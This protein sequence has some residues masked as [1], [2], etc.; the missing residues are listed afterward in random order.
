M[1][2]MTWRRPVP[3]TVC[4]IATFLTLPPSASA[5]FNGPAEC[6]GQSATLVGEAG[7]PLEGTDGP[8][9]VV[10][11]GVGFVE[12]YGGDDLVCITGSYDAEAYGDHCP[13]FAT[14]AGRD[15]IDSSMMAE[16]P[17]LLL[18]ID[19][20]RDAD[21]V[22]GGPV[23]EDVRAAEP[24]AKSSQR[25]VVDTAGGRDFVWTR[26][27]DVV[28][29]GADVDELTL[30]GDMS[31]GSFDAGGTLGD[32]LLAELPRLR[33]DASWQ[34]DNRSGE[35]VGDTGE[36]GISG[37]S[38]FRVRASGD[39]TFIGSD[40]RETFHFA[41]YNK[42]WIPRE[43]SVQLRMRGGNDEVWFYGGAPGG[44]LG[45]GDG[46]DTFHYFRS[47]GEGTNS[48]LPIVFNLASGRLEDVGSA[49]Y[50]RRALGFENGDVFSAYC[51]PNG[52]RC[53][54][55]P[56]TLTGTSGPNYLR[57]WGAPNQTQPNVVRGRGGDDVLVGSNVS[58]ILIGGEGEDVAKGRG[59]VDRCS[60]ETR[61]GCDD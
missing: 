28:T 17:Y 60:A 10:T 34:L 42:F 32:T 15:R 8:D 18:C 4:L 40:E 9:V 54:M 23:S 19:P 6:L 26:G 1:Q 57:V 52:G 30:L 56:L 59:G 16:D 45:G 12:T 48:R 3:F 47:N 21:E 49:G 50:T 29:L 61:N 41:N 53:G 36:I 35:I 43:S 13:V 33:S 5:T 38:T 55:A 22:T 11:N 2:A 25:D 39:F 51:A 37:F 27:D 58:D 31:G 44:R 24:T 46:N 7:S 14:G 20:G